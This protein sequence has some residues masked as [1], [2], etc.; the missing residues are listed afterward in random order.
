M[1]Q[2][3]PGGS[4]RSFGR[5]AS[6]ELEIQVCTLIK[7]GVDPLQHPCVRMIILCQIK[8]R[9][10]PGCSKDKNAI[11]KPQLSPLAPFGFKA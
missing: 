7:K 9:S 3:A 10:H 2:D 8:G 1:L 11:V 6:Q 4:G 5:L